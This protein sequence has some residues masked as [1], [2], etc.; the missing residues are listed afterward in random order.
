MFGTLAR[1]KR[2]KAA[3]GKGL[4]QLG[5]MNLHDYDGDFTELNT[6]RIDIL[7]T[8]FRAVYAELP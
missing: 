2:A 7:V 1:V 8:M 5:R 4:G 3:I 6:A